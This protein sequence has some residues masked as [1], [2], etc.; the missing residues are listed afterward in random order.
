[1]DRHG[2]ETVENFID[3]C[4]SLENLID[5]FAPYSPKRNSTPLPAELEEEDESRHVSPQ[6]KLKVHRGY[7]ENYINPFLIKTYLSPE[8]FCDRTRE[9]QTLLDNIKNNS[10]EAEFPFGYF[11]LSESD[12]RT[13]TVL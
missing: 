7:M 10:N 1:M 12:T 8:Y 2:V 9:T 13:Y 3:L 5:R 4:L 11:N 6:G